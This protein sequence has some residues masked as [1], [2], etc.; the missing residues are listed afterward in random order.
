MEQE[1][2]EELSPSTFETSSL[3]RYCE[4]RNKRFYK[5]AQFFRFT[6]FKP[7]VR[8][9]IQF[10]C[11]FIFTFF[12]LMLFS[13]STSFIYP[14]TSYMFGD[15]NMLQTIG[16]AIANGA[17]PYVDITDHKGLYFFWYE[18]LCYLIHP[19]FGF[20]LGEWVI[21]SINLFCIVK[22]FGLLKL[23]NFTC[24]ASLCIYLFMSGFIREGNLTED[25][26]LL[27]ITPALYFYIRGVI[28]KKDF[29][30]IIANII[31]GVGAGVLLFTKVTN[32]APLFF[33]VVFY[34]VYSIRNK[35]FK[36]LIINFF[37][38]LIPFIIFSA[39][40]LIASYYGGYLNE[41]LDAYFFT[42]MAYSG[43]HFT[44]ERF[45]LMIV[46]ILLAALFS[47]FLIKDYKASSYTSN[48]HLLLIISIIGNGL[49][50]AYFSTYPHYYIVVH[51]LVI[52]VTALL[53][54]KIY[55]SKR[56]NKEPGFKHENKSVFALLATCI[57]FLGATLGDFIYYCAGFYSFF[58]AGYDKIVAM[59]KLYQDIETKDRE[60]GEEG[61]VLAIDINAAF[62]LVNDLVPPYKEFCMQTWQD[63]AN[64]QIYDGLETYIAD[65]K[66]EWIV[67]DDSDPF[68]LGVL[69]DES[70]LKREALFDRLLTD[71]NY[72]KIDTY[73]VNEGGKD[74]FVD[75]VKVIDQ[76]RG[77]CLYHL[78]A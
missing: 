13:A 11:V 54:E 18:A 35:Q 75:D 31:C 22:I 15:S 49:V 62:Y 69:S 25:F 68:N 52:T 58:D 71:Y 3:Y 42:N 26:S 24:V 20:F 41:M 7:A 77:L 10:G 78:E 43:T 19:S 61:A 23:S 60:D 76:A 4:D 70:L 32:A 72:V 53:V 28:D 56:K 14:H 1:I 74:K 2:K 37:A 34:L 21:F 38:C 9:L 59:K 16:M 45:I 5:V 67:T 36:K 51:P 55:I 65:E 46:D 50:F 73:Y 47:V 6:N 12:F 66:P 30:F 27:F 33:L 17:T 40:P 8:N 29:Y 63:E 39:I 57:V 64:P 44:V 48:L